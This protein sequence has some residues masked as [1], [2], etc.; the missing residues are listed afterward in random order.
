MKSRLILA[1]GSPRR[2]E[3]LERLGYDFEVIVSS[4][5]ENYT[6]T[7]PEEIV[8]ELSYIKAKDIWERETSH[9]K[10]TGVCENESSYTKSSG[11]CESETGSDI[12]VLGADTIVASNGKVMGKPDSTEDAYKMIDGIQG[13][14]HQVYTGVTIIWGEDDYISFAEK[15]DV[16]VYPMQKDEIEAYIATG[17]PMDKAGAYGIQGEFGKFI[18]AIKGDYNN[19]VGL[20]LGRVYQEL[21][22][23]IKG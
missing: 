14:T 5:E 20:P 22:E 1:S 8:K 12:I 9:V 13:D 2:K 23:I 6:S 17:E 21:K 4:A 15:T 16:E 3:L 11:M 7:K 19:V 18:K 10:F